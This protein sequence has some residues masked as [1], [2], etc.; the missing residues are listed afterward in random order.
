MKATTS[1]NQSLLNRVVK[2]LTKYNALN[3][4]RD[5]ADNDG[6]DKLVNKLNT[7]CENSFAKYQEL[8]EGLP[9]YEQNRIEKSDLYYS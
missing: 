4:L 3:N 8:L 7:Q 9:K 5:N 6:D 2:A 1:K